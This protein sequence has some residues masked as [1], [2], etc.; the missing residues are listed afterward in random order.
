MRTRYVRLPLVGLM[1]CGLVISGCTH[2]L[3]FFENPAAGPFNAQ[4]PVHAV[5]GTAPA[6]IV[7]GSLPVVE[8]KTRA[9]GTSPITA[10]WQYIDGATS[11]NSKLDQRLL[12][13]LDARAGGRHEPSAQTPASVQSDDTSASIAH[14]VILATGNIIGSRFVQ[15]TMTG[16]ARLAH[17]TEIIYEDLDTGLITP[18]AALISA[19]K[20]ATLREML[21]EA[22]IPAPSSAPSPAPSAF[23]VPAP[24]STPSPSDGPA[25]DAELLSAISFTETGDIGVHVTR[26]P[27]SGLALETSV[28]VTLSPAAT[29]N[30]LSPAGEAIRQNILAGTV[31]RAPAPSPA[32][33][34][35]VN[36]D[37]VACVALTYD[38]G[39]NAQTTRLLEILEKHNVPATFFQQGG[40]VTSNAHIAASVAAAGHSIGNHTMTHPYLTQLSADRIVREVQG[41]QTAIEQAAGLIP[42]YIRPPYGATNATVSA[43]VGLPQISWDIDSLDWQSQ[44]KDIFIPRIM[45]LVK[46]GSIILLHDVH[47]ATVDGQDELITQLKSHG[48]YAVTLPQLFAGIELQPGGSYKCRGTHPGCTPSR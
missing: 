5:A 24:T 32:G 35:P 45:N 25:P 19:E 38:D 17:A 10:T 42:A 9:S 40:Y 11:F 3:G 14:E 30:V 34:K 22:E 6:K 36:C 20:T 1:V 46:P 37:I 18:S 48:Y 33:S 4:G 41:T 21:R 23:L 12:D 28:I 43:L 31:F 39:P 7:F 2:T 26:H 13:V 47:A 27:E 15:T 16:G 44:N 29:W 8:M